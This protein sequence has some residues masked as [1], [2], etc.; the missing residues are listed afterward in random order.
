LNAVRYQ[1]DNIVGRKHW[2]VGTILGDANTRAQAAA[3]IAERTHAD[4]VVYGIVRPTT[5]GRAEFTPEFYVNRNAASYGGETLGSEQFGKPVQIKLNSDTQDFELKLR[6]DTLRQFFEALQNHNEG[7]YVTAQSLYEQAL[8]LIDRQSDRQ[9]AAVIELFLGALQM[10][11]QQAINDQSFAEAE[12][13]YRTAWRYWPEYARPYLGRAAIL[14]RQVLAD[15]TRSSEGTKSDLVQFANQDCF[16]IPDTSL[17]TNA[18]R[19]AVALRCYEEAR[20][21]PV[22]TPTMDIAAKTAYGIGAVQFLISERLIDDQWSNAV[23]SFE[24]VGQ[25]YDSSDASAKRRLRQLMGHMLIQRGL[26]IIC[27][28]DCANPAGATERGYAQ[29][30]NYYQQGITLLQ[31]FEPGQTCRDAPGRCYAADHDS[32]VRYCRALKS[33]AHSL[34]KDAE[35]VRVCPPVW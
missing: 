31:E 30:L 29:A 34:G 27:P 16:A 22:Q 13:S 23:Q 1:T 11:M 18:A 28:P 3:V 24:V 6:L 10:D 21:A 12:R 4:I 7:D 14:Y 33:M 26:T 32:I 5:P 17:T 2:Q 25:L 19:L 15:K 35:A 9:L 8:K 20:N